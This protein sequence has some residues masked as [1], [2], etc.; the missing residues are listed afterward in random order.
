LRNPYSEKK[1]SHNFR[2]FDSTRFVVEVVTADNISS[3]IA[4][5]LVDKIFLILVETTF[6]LRIEEK[7]NKEREGH[8]KEYN[9][10]LY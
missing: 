5:R 1:Y 7:R 2:E 4:R 10:R 3:D 6:V 9:H 8:H